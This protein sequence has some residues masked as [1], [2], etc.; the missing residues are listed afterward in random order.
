MTIGP[1]V[2]AEEVLRAAA[3]C[4]RVYIHPVLEDY[5]LDL[6]AA[7]RTHPSIALGISPRGSLALQRASQALA[8]IQGRTYVLPDDIKRLLVPVLAHRIILTPTVRLRGG[9]VQAVLAE[10]A[11]Q[12][13]V[14]VE[15]IWYEARLAA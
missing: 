1:V 8:A 11:A 5:I 15:E 2:S 13:T 7:S 12:V 9:T 4:R 6:V 10:I 14:P 3:E